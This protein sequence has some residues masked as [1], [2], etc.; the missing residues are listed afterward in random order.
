MAFSGGSEAMDKQP[1]QRQCDDQQQ[2]RPQPGRQKNPHTQRP[3]YSRLE[4]GPWP[5]PALMRGTSYRTEL[6][7]S[8]VAD[9]QAGRRA[10]CV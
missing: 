5:R 6:C 3:F 7:I 4:A 8:G 10:G 9:S 2:P 1:G